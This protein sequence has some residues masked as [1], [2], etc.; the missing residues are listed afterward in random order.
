MAHSILNLY[1]FCSL[2][3]GRSPEEK[4]GNT[5]YVSTTTSNVPKNWR[6]K[7]GETKYSVARKRSIRDG[8]LILIIVTLWKFYFIL[9]Y[10]FN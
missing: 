5:K 9:I 8:D 6:N 10:F 4:L 2:C 3:I 1:F 7:K